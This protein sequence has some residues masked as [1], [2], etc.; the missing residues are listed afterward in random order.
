MM[1]TFL[2]L[3]LILGIALVASCGKKPKPQA[4]DQLTREILDA[5]HE[6]LL[7]TDIATKKASFTLTQ[8]ARNGQVQTWQSPDGVGISFDHGVLVA[9]RGMGEDVMS[10]D[11]SNTIR[12]LSGQTGDGFYT[13]FQTYLDGEYQT[14]FRSFQCQRTGIKR[15]TI[16]SYGKNRST[17]R[18]EETCYT[19][20]FDVTNIYWRGSDGLIWK[21]QQWVSPV[22]KYLVIERLV[23]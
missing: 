22:I 17:T 15:E 11:V 1:R 13:R 23:R 9:T 16:Q 2:N 19:P 3:V 12:M 7:L 6:P 14:Q 4:R 8:L 10:A 20:D 18:I 5:T 21:S